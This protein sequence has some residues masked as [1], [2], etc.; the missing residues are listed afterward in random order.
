[1]Q[2]PNLD[3]M[4]QVWIK[5]GTPQGS[6][7]DWFN[8]VWHV[9]RTQ[10]S[11]AVSILEKK[12]IIDWY[13]FLIHSKTGDATN[14]YFHV[15]LSLKKGINDGD[16]LSSLPEYCI[17]P[18]KINRNGVESIS[19][20]ILPLLKNNEIEEAWRIIGEQSELI[21]H[22]VNIHKEVEI[23][24]QQFIQFMHFFMNMT[25]LG[26]QSILPLTPFFRF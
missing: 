21:I 8:R 16:L 24:I 26:N 11:E 6:Y 10:V 5:I 12:G 1:M 3:R 7:Q 22:M 4:W 25:G 17:E 20:L 15:R 23:P 14:F 13:Q 9:I 2:K 19:G 18:E